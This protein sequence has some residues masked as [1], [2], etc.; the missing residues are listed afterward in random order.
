MCYKFMKIS[1]KLLAVSEKAVNYK[2]G[3]NKKR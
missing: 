3:P 1:T 2:E